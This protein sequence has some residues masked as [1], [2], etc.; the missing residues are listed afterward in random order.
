MV[1]VIQGGPSP[2]QTWTHGTFVQNARQVAEYIPDMAGFFIVAWEPDGAYTRAWQCSSKS[3]MTRTILPH[4]VAE[5]MRTASARYEAAA[6]IGELGFG[7]A[8][9]LDA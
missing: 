5:V 1:R 4:F 2:L 3:A 8:P 6:L 7:A 9:D